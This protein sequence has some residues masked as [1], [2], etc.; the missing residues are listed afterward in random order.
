MLNNLLHR[1]SMPSCMVI[2]FFFHITP[3]FA[4]K[5]YLVKGTVTELG[6]GNPLAG[7]KYYPRWQT[8]T[9]FYQ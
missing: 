1:L 2:V 3:L 9:Y 5:Q 4:Q 7:G 8:G 6:T